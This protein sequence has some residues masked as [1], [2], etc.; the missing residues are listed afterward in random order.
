[1]HNA[2]LLASRYPD[3]GKGEAEVREPRIVTGHKVYQ[4]KKTFNI[5][6]SF[7]LFAIILRYR[8]ECFCLTHT[9]FQVEEGGQVT[10]QCGVKHLGNMV[11]MWKQV[12]SRDS[13]S[14]DMTTCFMMT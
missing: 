1:M 8:V 9:M 13:T 3:H 11:L 4:V 14:D 10:L 7:S 6:E 2:G 5:S 12:G